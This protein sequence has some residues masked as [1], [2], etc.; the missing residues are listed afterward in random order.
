MNDMWGEIDLR[1]DTVTR[2]TQEMREAMARAEVGDD[3]YEED[4]TVRRLEQQAAE[5]L[6]K[7]AALFVPSGTFGNQLALFTHC[8]RGDEIILEES[9]HIVGNEM[10]A[11]GI[12]PGVQLHTIPSEKGIV[13][14]SG[15]ES[16]IRKGKGLHSP[17]T[18]LICM[19][20]IH[21]CGKLSRRNT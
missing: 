2:P 8:R 13:P 12:I 21:S 3:G 16:R 17:K 4:P 14:P 9:C 7:D 20:N 11:S 10:G 18:G 15:I 5:L 1:S 6:G 19:E